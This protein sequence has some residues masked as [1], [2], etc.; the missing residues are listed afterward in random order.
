MKVI[1]FISVMGHGRGGHFHSLNHISDAL[2]QYVNSNII[3][4]GPGK[5]QVISNNRSFHS[6]IDTNQ[7]NFIQFRKKIQDILK[8]ESPDILH[9]FDSNVYNILRLAVYPKKTRLILNLCGGPNPRFFPKISHLVVFSD[10]NRIWFQNQVKYKNTSIYLIPNR[11][12]KNEFTS[13]QESHPIKK[14]DNRFTFLRIGRIGKTYKKTLDASIQLIVK[15]SEK[16]LKN[17]MLY[18]IGTVED[19]EIFNEFKLQAAGLPIHFLIEDLYTQK[20]SDL[21]YLGDA[22]IAT[23]RGFMEATALQKPVL[24]LSVNSDI[25]I[26][27]NE[28]NFNDFFK[29]N[30]SERGL[31]SEKIVQE[32]LDKIISLISNTETYNIL[33]NFSEKIFKEKFDVGEGCKQYLEVYDD[34]MVTKI[35]YGIFSDWISQMYSFTKFFKFKKSN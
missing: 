10:E 29:T 20:A 21:L 32:N 6:H 27:I 14:D 30:F 8:V 33:S 35:R 34:I 31:T 3:S 5:S 1:F 16:G 2:T 4:V 18:I 9:C 23:G 19:E 7:Y 11:V 12:N 13:S 25:P 15:L 17:I 26:L 24:T 22:V 28:T